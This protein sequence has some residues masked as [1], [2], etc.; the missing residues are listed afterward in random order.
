MTLMQDLVKGPPSVELSETMAM[1]LA[2]TGQFTE[3]AAWQRDAIAA[4]L[5]SGQRARAA[6][7]ADNLALYEAHMPC[8]T[9][10]RAGESP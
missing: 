5:R 1:T 10:W 8:R 7:M 9:P 3:A 4:V 6:R 2:E